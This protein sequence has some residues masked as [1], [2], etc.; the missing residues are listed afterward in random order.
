MKPGIVLK[1]KINGID[2]TLG[3]LVTDHIWTEL[4]ERSHR[5]GLDYLIVDMEHGYH[6]DQDVARSCQI[7]RLLQFPVLVRTVSSDPD[8]VRRALDFGPCGLM[9]P[10]IE[11]RE[12]LNEIQSAIFLPPRGNRRPGGM[13]VLWIDKYD[14]ETWRLDFE[15]DLIILPQIE[16]KRGLDNVEAIVNHEIVTAMAIGPYDLSLS[17]GFSK[18][19]QNP[20][21]RK[22]IQ[23][24]RQV[25]IKSG[26]NTWIMG[27]GPQLLEEGFTFLC[28]GEPS[29]MLED[30]FRR[31]I[32]AANRILNK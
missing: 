14:D 7:G 17:L 15:N 24:V 8:T 29:Y 30:E 1:N 12:Q 3:I 20:E 2:V 26:K 28:I 27:D 19:P 18:D 16:T 31:R 22:A 25:S 6:S 11:G 4:V 21:F 10:A 13:G 32:E 5:A 23:Q 9:F